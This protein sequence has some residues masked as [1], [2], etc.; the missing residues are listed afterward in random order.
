MNFRILFF[1]FLV[2]SQVKAALILEPYLSFENGT[3]S[4]SQYFNGRTSPDQNLTG[5]SYGAL[6]SL[7]VYKGLGL[8]FTYGQS[9]FTL[10]DTSGNQSVTFRDYGPYLAIPI[11]QR[12]NLWV[13][14]VL[15]SSSD[16][17]D[18]IPASSGTIK[19][20]GTKFGAG[21]MVHPHVRLNVEFLNLNYDTV[22]GGN[23]SDSVNLDRS[24]VIFTVSFPFLIWEPK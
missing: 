4:G 2:S 21:Y 24:S 20:T 17:T 23:S 10:K 19:G 12:W 8:N 13:A 5:F 6:L 1:L 9:D 16:Y 15:S 11:N 3:F 7:G 14:Y 22:N 18:D